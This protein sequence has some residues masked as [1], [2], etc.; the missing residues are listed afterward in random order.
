EPIQSQLVTIY[1]REGRLEEAKKIGE[2]FPDYEPIQSQMVTI[3]IK[4]GRIEEAKK[5]G[6]KF[7]DN[8][9]IQSQMVTIYMK[10]G[11]IGEAKKIGE[12]FPDNEPIQSQMVTIYMEEGRIKDEEGIDTFRIVLSNNLPEFIDNVLNEIREK[13]KDIKT[14]E[15][16]EE[17]SNNW[18]KIILNCALAES[19]N[20]KTPAQQFIKKLKRTSEYQQHK[21]IINALEQRLQQKTKIFDVLFYQ[22]LIDRIKEQENNCNIRYTTPD[23]GER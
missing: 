22:E 13:P 15:A 14:K 6:E 21:Q 20:T 12:K 10:E 4:E 9:P 18:I 17:I 3:Y 23:V 5:I 2:N 11:R 7:P 19:S 16:I 8:E 1:I